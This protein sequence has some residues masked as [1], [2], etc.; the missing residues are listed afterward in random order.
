MVKALPKKL[1]YKH[2]VTGGWFFR[3]TK[4]QEIKQSNCRGYY[5]VGLCSNN[6]MT[7]PR[8]NR[9]VAQAFIP[10]PENKPCVNHING[11]KTDNR[12]EN[13]EWCTYKENNTHAVLT[14]LRKEKTGK[15]RF[16]SKSVICKKTNKVYYTIQDA[17]K[18]INVH[19]ATLSRALRGVYKNKYD[20]ELYEAHIL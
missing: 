1:P 3:L 15:D 11:I 17:A 19:P 6:V 2:A 18:D 12:V 14:G 10:N 7:Q 16:N 9:L 20:L 13:L 8:T 5:K 4:E